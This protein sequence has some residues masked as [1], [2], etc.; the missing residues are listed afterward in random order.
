MPRPRHP[1]KEIESAVKYAE[2]H[3][4]EY[5]RQ[6]SHVWG[7][8]HC[9][10]RG[11]DSRAPRSGASGRRERPQ[12][13]RTPSR[14]IG[15]GLNRAGVGAVLGFMIDRSN[16]DRGQLVRCSEIAMRIDRT[17]TRSP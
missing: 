2:A 15:A 10:G 12:A 14:A 4:W 8:L 1:N 5:V 7:V 9:A 17:A 3:G 6:G 11:L 13:E 16:K